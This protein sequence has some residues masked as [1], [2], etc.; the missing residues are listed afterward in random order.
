MAVFDL[1][2]GAPADITQCCEVALWLRERLDELGLEVYPKTS[3]SKGMQLYVPLN[4]PVSFAETKD[5]AQMMAQQIEAEHPESV[6]SKMAKKLRKG[7]VFI[8]WSQNSE[9]KTTVCVY[10]LRAKER[11]TVST[12]LEWNEVETGV[13]KKDP[14]ALTFDWAQVLERV[15]KF[16]DLFEPIL[17]HKQKLPKQD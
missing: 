11:P 9:S 4:T 17:T 12:P 13:K 14:K 16:G 5:F 15:K 7:K 2:P 3:G 6:V 10:S 8:D 1:D